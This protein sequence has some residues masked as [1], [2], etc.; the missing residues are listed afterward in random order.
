MLPTGQLIA[1]ERCRQGLVEGGLE[2]NAELEV[3]S[4]VHHK[5]VVI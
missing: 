5:N 2:F 3:L 1:I 4:R